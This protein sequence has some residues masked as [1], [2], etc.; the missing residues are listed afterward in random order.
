MASFW[1]SRWLNG[2]TL[3]ARF[4]L[5]HKHSRRENRTV[6]QALTDNRWINDIDHNLNHEIIVEYTKLWEVLE[7]IVLSDSQ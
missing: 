1:S 6:A 5:L 7:D 3:A 2:E 4:Q